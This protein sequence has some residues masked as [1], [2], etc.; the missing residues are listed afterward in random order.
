MGAAGHVVARLDLRVFGGSALTSDD[1][2][3]PKDRHEDG[4]PFPFC[5]K[6]AFYS[7]WGSHNGS[8]GC[9]FFFL[10]LP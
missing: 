6:T 7:S 9:Y 10:I 3:V 2:Q 1:I 5:P 8:I 4:I